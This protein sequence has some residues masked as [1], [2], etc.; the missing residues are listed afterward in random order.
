MIR[1][2]QAGLTSGITILQNTTHSFAPSMCAASIRVSG[3]LVS[4]N[5][6]IRYSPSGAAKAGRISD[7]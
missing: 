1:V 5:C 6:F 7:Q 3:I 2:S 4:I